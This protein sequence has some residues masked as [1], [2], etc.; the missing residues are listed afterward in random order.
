M[1]ILKGQPPAQVQVGEK[2][3]A[4]TV[5]ALIQLHGARLIKQ[6][7]RARYTGSEFPFSG[8]I[9]FGWTWTGPATGTLWNGVILYGS[10]AV[11]EVAANTGITITAD[12]QY[13]GIGYNTQDGTVSLYGPNTTYPV[14]DGQIYRAAMYKFGFDATSGVAELANPLGILEGGRPIHVS[15]RFG[16][17][18]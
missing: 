7:T 9:C 14:S 15:A 5:N 18:V 1:E 2:L 10:N 6:P 8:N 16:D 13:V 11:I 4:S 3:K 17:A 12:G